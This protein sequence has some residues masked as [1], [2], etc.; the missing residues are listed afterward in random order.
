VKTIE[1]SCVRGGGGGGGE[2]EE[3]EEV[4]I[5]ILIISLLKGFFSLR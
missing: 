1:A 4:N 5:L 3:E 2:G